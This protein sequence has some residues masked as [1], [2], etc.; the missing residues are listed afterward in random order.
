MRILVTGGAGY[1]G[2]HVLLELA[3]AGHDAVVFDNLTTG[4]RSSV[5]HGRLVVGDLA[6]PAAIA[7]VFDKY[8]FDAVIHLAAD[9]VIA[10]SVRHPLHTYANNTRNTLN[11]LQACAH[12]GVNQFIFSS[13][14]AVY[15]AQHQAL[16]DEDSPLDP[17]NPY[18][19]SKMMSERMM[20]D[21]AAISPF[22]CIILR[23]FNASGAD[24]AGRIGE[25]RDPPIRAIPNILQAALGMRQHAT[26]H[27]AD[28]PTE[29]GT[30]I[31]DYLHVEDLA[32]AHV[33][34]LHYLDASGESTI[35]NC[36]YGVGHS[37]RQVVETVKIIT[38][39]DFPVRI[40]PRRPGDP[41][42]LVAECSRIQ[43]VLGWSP[44]Y[45]DLEIIVTHA[46]QWETLRGMP[47]A[48]PLPEPIAEA[49]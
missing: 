38:G 7:R 16:I 46:L 6:N 30:C 21:Y 49:S 31:R 35:L 27:G 13:T 17:I 33:D 10:D 19:A 11:L 44:R 3:K 34:A 45:A 40:G 37:L 36:G 8:A 12:H 39:A 47:P 1:V 22:R 23:Y 32:R 5:L 28:Y 41:P 15:G 20:W 26:I 43:S 2:S 25:M 4:H 42:R 9:A 48:L 18:G 14:A 29:D 24:P